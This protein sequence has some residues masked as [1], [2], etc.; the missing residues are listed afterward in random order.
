MDVIGQLFDAH[1]ASEISR[2]LF[3]RHLSH[4]LSEDMVEG[5]QVYTLVALDLNDKD[6]E[7]ARN[8]FRVSMGL[9]GR[10]PEIDPEWLAIK[11]APMGFVTK[12]MIAF[13][14]VI[15]ALGF[16]NPQYKEAAYH[17]LSFSLAPLEVWRMLTPIF[18]HFS[19]MHILFNMMW[20]KDLGSIFEETKGVSQFVLFVVVTGVLSNLGQFMISGPRFGGM[21]GVV[22]ALLGHLWIYSKTHDNARFSL[23]KRDI[24]LMIGWYFLC[25]TGLLGPIANMAHGV[26]LGLGMLWGFFPLEGRF[27]SSW[28]KYVLAAL[29]FCFGTYMLEVTF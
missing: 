24:V 9:P 15:Y 6:L 20:L 4:S 26:G 27:K 5:R 10:P 1:K 29:F 28:V 3:A 21:S 18:L 8:F 17:L 25:F 7:E 13:S 16:F 2:E 11:S 14:V 19:L 23:P 12:V 22:Y